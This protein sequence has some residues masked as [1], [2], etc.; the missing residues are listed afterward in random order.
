[1]SIHDAG[2]PAGFGAL[3]S[4]AFDDGRPIDPYKLGV[5]AR[6]AN[7]FIA[8]SAPVFNLCW[9]AYQLSASGT[10]V[11][12]RY[13]Y[14]DT[15]GGD[16]QEAVPV[17]RVPKKPGAKTMRVRLHLSVTSG[18]KVAL[19]VTTGARPFAANLDVTAAPNAAF[20]TAAGDALALVDLSGVPC[21]PGSSE[22]IGLWI[23]GTDLGVA[24]NTSLYGS[25]A[26]GTSDFAGPHHVRIHT[27]LAGG[28]TWGTG[29]TGL[30]PSEAGANV[31]LFD[32]DDTLIA[33]RK[34]RATIASRYTTSGVIP[35]G[36]ISWTVPLSSDQVQRAIGGTWTLTIVPSYALANF[37]G[38]TEQLGSTD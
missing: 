12:R 34:V 22:S 15:A 24:M 35:V 36:E 6:N 32:K 21:L 5:L 2:I 33:V 28:V 31:Q 25:P 38:V 20:Y 26:S 10:P 30:V 17:F 37:M 3:D 18:E 23:R 1:M 11:Q 7:R 9:P 27:S 4:L 16:W 8:K 29:S 14:H 19:Q 13:D